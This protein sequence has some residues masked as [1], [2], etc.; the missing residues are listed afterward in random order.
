M[1]QVS[2]VLNWEADVKGNSERVGE[3]EDRGGGDLNIL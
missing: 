3:R 2:H 1:S